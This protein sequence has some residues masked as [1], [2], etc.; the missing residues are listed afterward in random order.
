MRLNSDSGDLSRKLL[1]KFSSGSSR[2]S[3]LAASFQP[4]PN[5]PFT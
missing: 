2:V 1:N 4:S 3:A 5:L